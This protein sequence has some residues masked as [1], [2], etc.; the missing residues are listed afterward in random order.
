[1]IK[2][3]CSLC[4]NAE[5]NSGAVDTPMHQANLASDADDPTGPTP[6]NR[7]GKPDEI[8]V[9]AGLLLSDQSSFTTGSL[10]RVDGGANS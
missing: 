8:A 5:P 1:M 4:A 9:V 6:I 10:W 3:H 7:P 2:G